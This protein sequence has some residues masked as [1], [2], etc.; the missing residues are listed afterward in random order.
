[1]DNKLTDYYITYNTGRPYY[2]VIRATSRKLAEKAFN[3]IYADRED[4]ELHSTPPDEDD[5][6]SGCKH[7]ITIH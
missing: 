3:D 1:M 2:F 7:T 6:P 4:M 5:C